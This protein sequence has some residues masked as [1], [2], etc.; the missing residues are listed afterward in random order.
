M[1]DYGNLAKVHPWW[2]ILATGHGSPPRLANYGN[3][4]GQGAT[5]GGQFWLSPLVAD[6]SNFAKEYP[7]VA[8]YYTWPLGTHWWLITVTCCRNSPGS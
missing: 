8:D 7:L 6:F 4:H 2:L 5:S 1:A 3:L